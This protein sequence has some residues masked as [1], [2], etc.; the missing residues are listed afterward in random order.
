MAHE[1]LA[2]VR[3]TLPDGPAEMAGALGEIAEAWSTFLSAFDQYEASR[4]VTFNVNETRAKGGRPRKPRTPSVG[5]VR[6]IL[7]EPDSEAA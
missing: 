5:E 7:R 2:S 1:V 3:V 6:G 4:E